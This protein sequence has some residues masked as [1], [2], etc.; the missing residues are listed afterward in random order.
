MSILH[1]LLAS[2]GIV[3]PAHRSADRRIFLVSEHLVHNGDLASVVPDAED[4]SLWQ[5]PSSTATDGAAIPR[6]SAPK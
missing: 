6:Q 3:R 1:K 4:T 5:L 2:P